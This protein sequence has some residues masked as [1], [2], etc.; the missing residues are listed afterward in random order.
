[1][2]NSISKALIMVSGVLV[3][4]LVIA[5]ITVSFNKIGQWASV[6]DDEVLVEQVQK[7]NKE[8]EVYDKDLMY[9]VDVISCLNKAKSNNDKID[10]K[11]A[12]ELDKEYEVQVEFN[13]KNSELEQALIVYHSDNSGKQVQYSEGDGPEKTQNNKKTLGQ[14][15]F[16]F[17]NTKYSELSD[18][19]NKNTELKT[20]QNSKVSLDT[21]KLKLT[22]DSLKN[23][24][25]EKLLSA[26]NA[27]SQIVKNTDSV[28]KNNP[29]GWTMVEVRTALY[30]LKQRK[31][32]CT[33]IEYNAKTGRVNKISFQEI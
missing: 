28:T 12:E 20:N 7:F 1:M 32:K 26:A 8:Y 21:N 23:S 10:G 27:V 16:T 5:L 14:L 9:G 31:F 17:L 6:K 24:S 33:G 3:A 19:F 2:D 15:G 25:I 13:L 30:D 29:K 18:V 22:K 11:Y 4:M